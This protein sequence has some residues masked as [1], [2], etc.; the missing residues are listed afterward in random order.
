[1]FTGSAHPDTHQ[2]YPH[3]RISYRLSFAEYRTLLISEYD[4]IVV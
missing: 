4:P 1:M 2:R 3:L